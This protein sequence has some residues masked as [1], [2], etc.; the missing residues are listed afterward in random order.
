MP[1]PPGVTD[2]DFARAL[3]ELRNAIGRD[4]VFTSDEDVNLYRDAYSPFKGEEE[5][6]VPSAAVAPDKRRASAGDRQDRE[7]LQAAAVDDL[8][9]PELGLRRLGARLLRQR[10]RRL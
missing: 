4:W 1:A 2:R 6:R 10:R 9:G 7:P 5:D 8:D 3:E